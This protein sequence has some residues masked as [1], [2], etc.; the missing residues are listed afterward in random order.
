MKK[1]YYILILL[2]VISYSCEDVLD[3]APLDIISEDVVFDDPTLTQA[4]INNLYSELSFLNR[5]GSGFEGTDPTSGLSDEGRQGRNWHP[6]Y[7]AWKAGQLDANGSLLQL[8]KYGTIRKANEFLVKIESSTGISEDLKNEMIGQVRFAR[9]IVY[10]YMVKRYGGIPLVTEPQAIDAPEEE[11]FLPR[12]KEIDIYDFILDEMDAI[13]NIL[14]VSNDNIGMPTK[15]AALALKS[16]AAMFAA[17]IATWGDVDLDDVVGIPAN[18]AQRFWQ[19]SYDAS[20]EII[21][22]GNYELYNQIPDDKTENFRKLF[23]DE[24]GANKERIF[25]WQLTGVN[26]HSQYDLFMS[27]FQFCP[28]WGGSNTSVY[29]EMVEEFENID[30]TPGTFDE[31]L[32]TSQLWDLKEFFANKDPRFNATIYYEGMEWKGEP[33]ENWG[34]VVKPDGSVVGDGFYEGISAKGRSHSA[35]GYAGGV[36]TGFNVLKYLDE[37]LVPV[38]HNKTKIDFMVFRAGGILLNYAEAAFELGKP[39]D[40]LWSVNILRER[41]GIALLDDITRDKIRHERKVELAFENNRWWDLRRWRIAVDAITRNFKGIY[42]YK[43]SSTGK[44]KIE[45]N[46][47]AQGGIPAAF[48]ERHYYLPIKPGRISNN[49]KLVENPL[50]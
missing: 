2:I 37:T 50:Y 31:A 27:P 7:F 23:V 26:V 32:A 47:N 45:M 38:A 36:I 15:Y 33:I 34:G 4:Y 30:G 24:T 11:L 3:K 18:E 6:L 13:Q 14:P 5:D 48:L 28:G 42:T 8:W 43:D 21:N 40:A 41:A 49:P 35:G 17:S 29:L 19:A 12:N 20:E 10:F 25:S 9:A 22:S 46:N 16:Q 1:I 39:D 44:F